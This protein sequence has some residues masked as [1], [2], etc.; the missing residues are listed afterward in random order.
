MKVYILF[1]VLIATLLQPASAKSDLKLVALSPHTVEMLFDLGLGNTIVG[2]VDYADYPEQAKLLPRVGGAYGLSI[3]KIIA[4]KPDYVV[5]WRGGN[6]ASDIAALEKL[7]L[8]VIDSSP[9]NIYGVAQ[10]Y[11]RIGALLGRA[12]QGQLIGG[13]IDKSVEQLEALYRN[14]QP[15]RTFYQ[16]WPEP[17][18]TINSETWTHR[19]LQL[20]GAE[21]VFAEQSANYPQISPEHVIAKQ[22]AVIVIPV[23]KSHNKI[24]NEKWQDWDQ[25]PAVKKNQFVQA[26]ADLLHRFT[27]RV[28]QGATKLCADID[29]YR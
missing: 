12:E 20:C 5:A 16:M 22:P 27:K 3:E 24:S 13:E 19:L 23:D 21:N 25:I 14:K 4:L 1:F 10:D 9:Q 2:T 7:G 26:D 29:Q 8:T 17:L 18:M 28:L 11:R 15:V 6:K